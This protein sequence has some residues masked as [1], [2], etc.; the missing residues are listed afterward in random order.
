MVKLFLNKNKNKNSTNKENRVNI[1]LSDNNKILPLSNIDENVNAY[2]QYVK[3]KKESQ[4]YRL[5]FNITPLCSNVLFNKVTEIVYHEG[6]ND[7]RYFGINSGVT[8]DDDKIKAY[9]TY[10]GVD[11][12]D[13]NKLDLLRD[14]GFSH[15]ECGGLVYHCGYDIFNNHTLRKKSFNVVNKLNNESKNKKYFNTIYDFKRDKDGYEIENQK[16]YK[17]VGEDNETTFYEHLYMVDTIYSFEECINENL[18]EKDGWIGFINTNTLNVNNFNEVALNKCMNNNKA[19]EMIDM[20]PDRS[21]FSFIPKINK[22]RKNRLENNWDYCL[23]YPYE[24]YYDNELV[25]YKCKNNIVING[26]KAFIYD[27]NINDEDIDV[28]EGSIITLRTVIK[29]NLTIN[30]L[31]NIVL[32]G[33]IGVGENRREEAISLSNNEMVVGTGY[34]GKNDGY[35]F[36]IYSDEIIEK[37][38]NFENPSKVEIRVRK[39]S[40]GSLCEYYFRKFRRI[41]NFLNTNVYNDDII[42]DD[43]I[44][45]HLSKKFNSTIN[46][47]G[48]SRTI[49]NDRNVQLLY[50]DDIYLKGLKDNLGREISEIYLTIV[51]NNEGHKE[52]YYDKNYTAS[53]I[54]NSRCFSKVTSGVEMLDRQV[55]DYN[56]HVINNVEPDIIDMNTGE[57][58]KTMVKL[59]YNNLFNYNEGVYTNP[60]VLE[61]DININGTNNSYDFFGDVVEFDKNKLIETTLTDVFHR[62]NTV[63]REKLDVEYRD[64][65]IDEIYY[66]DYDIEGSGF[67]IGDIYFNDLSDGA[68]IPINIDA[69]GYY[70]KPHYKIELKKFNSNVKQGEHTRVVFNSFEYDENNKTASRNY[71]FE[72]LD[73]IYFYNKKTNEKIIGEVVEIKG[74]YKTELLIKIS[75]PNGSDA[76]SYFVY[77]PNTEKPYGAYELNDGSGRYLWRELLEE[78]EYDINDDISKYIFTNNAHYINK[79]ILFKLYRQD[80]Y[81]EFL[82][83]SINA[84]TPLINYFCVVGEGNDYSKYE[85]MLSQIENELLC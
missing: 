56:I 78:Q 46:G 16:K 71:Y 4:T 73:K 77:K 51:K 84:P 17:I 44:K 38:N 74:K 60:K 65:H 79:Q 72:F 31:V 82:I 21:L 85:T 13:I 18:V 9:C 23:T 33:I 48:F 63:Q 81:G 41:P 7:C 80:P 5:S 52:W 22:Y 14:T 39:V 69:E 64:I 20:Y 55:I 49:Y 12:K 29:H 19:C 1:F 68:I 36:S 57:K 67:T 75:L 11:I 58:W 10:K 43:E 50:N 83:S 42:S 6:S 59:Y 24:N 47:L 30:S 25:Q 15:P 70:Y 40:D 37:I 61:D 3:E 66:D 2:E 54:T 76:N 62:F 8:I 26:L 34:N 27:G 32:I 35:Y 28:S 45:A 53:T